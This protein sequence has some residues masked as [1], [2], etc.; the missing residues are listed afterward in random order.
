M[1]SQTRLAILVVASIGAVVAAAIFVATRQGPKT[2]E[3]VPVERTAYTVAGTI[4][5]LEDEAGE[6]LIDH[7][8]IPE[9]KD[10][11][12]RVVGMGAMVM[13]F[14]VADGVDLGDLSAGDDVIFTFEV[15]WEPETDWE[16]T[17]IERRTDDEPAE[18]DSP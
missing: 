17:A 11:S 9:F 2:E 5:V 13:A 16:L 4:D 7:E 6:M 1:N 15:W 10:G 3:Q 14:K 8:P 12:G 18:N